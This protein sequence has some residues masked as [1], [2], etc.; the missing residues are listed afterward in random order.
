MTDCE[1]CP[2]PM[3]P[4][5]VVVLSHAGVGGVPDVP[6]AGVILCPDCACL[7]LWSA[8]GYPEPEMPGWRQVEKLRQA[9]FG[10]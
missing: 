5:A 9:A 1:N 6:V 4:H 10:G 2:H 8:M 7:A 3:D